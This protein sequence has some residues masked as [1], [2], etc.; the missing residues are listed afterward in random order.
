MATPGSAADCRDGN[1][2][3]NDSRHGARPGAGREPTDSSQGKKSLPR[4]SPDHQR[5]PRKPEPARQARRLRNEYQGIQKAVITIAMLAASLLRTAGPRQLHL[6][7]VGSCG[8]AAE[9]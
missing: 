5:P 3:I 4:S 8:R 9:L 6:V 7:Q 2:R 1:I